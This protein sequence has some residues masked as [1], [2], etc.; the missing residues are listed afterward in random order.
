M[1]AFW[2]GIFLTDLLDKGSGIFLSFR[3]VKSSY[4]CYEGCNLKKG[5]HNGKHPR[6]NLEQLSVFLALGSGGSCVAL[7]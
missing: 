1:L 6:S 2:V 4:L 5:G 7:D 3:Y